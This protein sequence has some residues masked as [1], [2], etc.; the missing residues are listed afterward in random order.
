[1]DSFP[2]CAFE[3]QARE[4]NFPLALLGVKTESQLGHVIGKHFRLDS[5]TQFCEQKDTDAIR[6][7]PIRPFGVIGPEHC[8]HVFIAI[9]ERVQ[10]A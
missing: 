2:L 8:L 9:L 3:A 1:M 10:F 4:Q 5:R 7:C 6:F